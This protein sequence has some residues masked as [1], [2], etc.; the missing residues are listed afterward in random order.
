MIG[1][2]DVSLHDEALAE[3]LRKDGKRAK[4]RKL[5]DG[6]EADGE[7]PATTFEQLWQSDEELDEEGLSELIQGNVWIFG[8]I[9]IFLCFLVHFGPEK[10]RPTAVCVARQ[11]GGQIQQF[12]AKPGED[13][14]ATGQSGCEG[15]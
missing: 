7:A 9:L 12:G 8:T 11:R 14:E 2:L 1:K 13:G 3:Q 15:H 5:E 4:K 6:D 10:G